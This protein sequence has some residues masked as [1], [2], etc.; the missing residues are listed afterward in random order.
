[1]VGPQALSASEQVVWDEFCVLGGLIEVRQP[2]HTYFRFDHISGRVLSS[3]IDRFYVSHRPADLV[4]AAPTCQVASA[5]FSSLR[6]HRLRVAD[7]TRTIFNAAPDHYPLAFLFLPFLPRD[8]APTSLRG[9]W[10]LLCSRPSLSVIGRGLPTTGLRARG[11]SSPSLI[12][13]PPRSFVIVTRRQPHR[14]FGF[15]QRL[16]RCYVNSPSLSRFGGVWRRC[17]WHTKS[18]LLVSARSMGFRPMGAPQ[19]SLL[20]TWSLGPMLASS[21]VRMPTPVGCPMRPT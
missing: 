9:W 19:T 3:R 16:W 5:P 18:W 7:G 10:A 4:V 6:L 13:L 2:T 14:R 8:G 17:F 12:G 21:K 11:L 15:C 20:N 1:M